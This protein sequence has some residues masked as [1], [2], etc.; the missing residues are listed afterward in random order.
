[1]DENNQPLGLAL[2]TE[3]IKAVSRPLAITDI[4]RRATTAP[5]FIAIGLGGL[6]PGRRPALAT[7]DVGAIGVGVVPV[8]NL[9]KDHAGRFPF[10]LE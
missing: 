3:Q 6:H 9:M 5:Q 10:G 1:M 7:G 8:G 4:K 2:G